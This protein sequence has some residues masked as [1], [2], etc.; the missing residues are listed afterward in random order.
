MEFGKLED[1]SGVDFTLRPEHPGNAAVLARAGEREGPCTVYLG[2]T[3]WSMREWVGSVYPP[4][5]K[6]KDYLR[7]YSRQFNTIEFNTT[8]YRVPDA[9]TV[10]RWYEESADDF[11]FCPKIPQNISHRSDL[12]FGNGMMLEFAE[13]IQGLK[14]KLGPCFLQLP[15]HFGPGQAKALET[16]LSHYAGSLQMAVELRHPGWFEEAGENR[17]FPLLEQYGA[18]VVITDVAGRRDVA[19]MRLSAPF[20]MVRFV[21]N[22]LHPSDYARIDEWVERM[23]LWEE[24]GLREIYFFPHEP[25]NLLA[26]ELSVYLLEKIQSRMKAR[27]R[28]PRL[29]GLFS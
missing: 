10:A 1:I 23:K 2:C 27:V 14:E 20:A 5:T 25:D 26:P 4:G 22:G 17:L 13:V 21:G 12:G 24:M 7:Y 15:Q 19:H 18:G 8:H 16:F 6:A 9:A 29:L 11:R 3:G 28:G